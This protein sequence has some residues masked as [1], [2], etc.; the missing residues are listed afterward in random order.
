[1][2]LLVDLSNYLYGY[3]VG[4]HDNFLEQGMQLEDLAHNA[5]ERV[6]ISLYQLKKKF[7]CKD[8]DIIICTDTQSW[9]KD[10]YPYYKENRKKEREKSSVDT[11]LM[12]KCFDSIID[13]LKK[14]F[15]FIV[16]GVHKCEADDI[17]GTLALDFKNKEDCV[18]IVSKDKDFIQ[19]YDDNVL[20]FDPFKFKF[21]NEVKLGSSKDTMI[22]NNKKDAMKFLLYQ[23][24]MGDTS[25]GIPN[26]K[27]DD[28]TFVNPTKRQKP[29]G[30]KTI[31]KQVKNKMDL[32][33]IYEE[34]ES[35]FKRNTKLIDL[36]YVP[37]EYR[38]KIINKYFLKSVVDKTENINI[39]KYCQDNRFFDVLENFNN[40][41]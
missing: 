11:K 6:I 13:D 40:I 41:I 19:L 21:N 25:D 9:R 38:Q 16:L 5:K 12:Y 22:I 33:R 28:D 30:I 10:Y 4:S 17:I 39:I 2:K 37:K 36:R 15:N 18:I 8:T 14:Y 32:K 31:M 24:L 7:R 29:F 35:N 27:S 23:T 3:Y 20:I 1:M 34:Y 26:I